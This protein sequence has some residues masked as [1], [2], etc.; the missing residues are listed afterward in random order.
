ME[1]DCP[2]SDTGAAE[3]VSGI[4]MS[5]RSPGLKCFGFSDQAAGRLWHGKCY[6]RV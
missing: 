6:I 1:A 2:I 5:E 3:A 4:A